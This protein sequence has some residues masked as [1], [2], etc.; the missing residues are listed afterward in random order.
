MTTWIYI[1][2]GPFIFWRYF[3]SIFLRNPKKSALCTDIIRN[4]VGFLTGMYSFFKFGIYFDF[5]THFES[6]L[7]PSF[8]LFEP[9]RQLLSQF[10]A[11]K[12]PMIPGR[13]LY[14]NKYYIW[15][16]IYYYIIFGWCLNLFWRA[17]FCCGE[18]ALA[19]LLP[20]ISQG[21]RSKYVHSI[22]SPPTVVT[23]LLPTTIHTTTS[24]QT[25]I[26]WAEWN[27]HFLPPRYQ[28]TNEVQFFILF[29]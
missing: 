3:L 13:A 29:D 11:G 14:M 22:T 10:A 5:K 23:F 28:S 24:M 18:V 12:N 7:T 9:L 6:F 19:E 4:Y 25:S 1:V 8:F 27:I 15:G 26:E 2:R 21:G 16:P 17:L 20:Q